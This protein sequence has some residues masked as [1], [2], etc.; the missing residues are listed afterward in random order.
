MP[1]R[2]GTWSSLK[3]RKGLQGRS[4]DCLGLCCSILWATGRLNG[5]IITKNL[6]RPAGR[7]IVLAR[8]LV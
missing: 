4:V 7:I 5:P 8:P 2:K 6:N 1:R 3:V